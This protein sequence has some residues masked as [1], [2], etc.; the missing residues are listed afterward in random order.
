MTSGADNNKKLESVWDYPRPPLVERTSKHIQVIFAGKIIADTNKA[1]RVLETS[2]PPT[3][4]IPPEDV[5]LDCLSMTNRRSVCE[6]KGVA[7]YY[8]LGIGQKTSRDAAWSYL[9]PNTGY[10]AIKDHISFYPSKVD[11][12]Y[13]DGEE[14]IAQQGDFYGGWITSDIIGPFKG[15][16]G[17][18]GW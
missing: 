17:T 18:E 3:Y 10:E 16:A 4:Y 13:V 11:V 7:V 5:C 8:D 2:H 14:V 15:V 9:N 12:C 6:Y 1:Y